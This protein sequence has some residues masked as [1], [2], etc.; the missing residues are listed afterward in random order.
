M[1]MT[2]N[3][4]AVK[5]ETPVLWLVPTREEPGIR[6]ADMLLYKR[7]PSNPAT[8]LAEPDSDH[9]QAPRASAA[10]VIEWMR[11]LAADR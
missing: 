3:V 9:L 5:A 7:L 6:D 10:I 11:K 8:K 2:R 1:N 4:A